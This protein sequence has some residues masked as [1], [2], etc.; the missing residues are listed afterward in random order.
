WDAISSTVLAFT[1]ANSNTTTG[2]KYSSYHVAY[3]RAIA[4]DEDSGTVYVGGYFSYYGLA[5]TDAGR[6]TFNGLMKASADSASRTTWSQVTTGSSVGLY[7]STVNTSS[8]VH[9]LTWV[10]NDGV[11]V[12]G[13]FTKLGGATPASQSS[14]A[15]T[16]IRYLAR[17]PSTGGSAGQ[18]VAAGGGSAGTAWL[19]STVKGMIGPVSVTKSGSSANYFIPFG[20]FTNA[21][22]VAVNDA[23]GLMATDASS[24]SA[25]AAAAPLNN[26]V[27]AVAVTADNRYVYVG[28][29]FTSLGGVANANYLA[30]YD[31]TT[32]AWSV[33]T[34]WYSSATTSRF[35][36]RA[37]KISGSYI[38][39]AGISETSKGQYVYR[40]SANAPA[41]VSPT[42]PTAVSGTYITAS[43]G[44][45]T[46]VINAIEFD[47]SGRLV[48]GGSFTKLN[49]TACPTASIGTIKNLFRVVLAGT[50]ACEVIGGVSPVSDSGKVNT[51]VSGFVDGASL[52]FVGGE[53]Q[54]IDSDATLDNVAVWDDSG[55]SAGTGDWLGLGSVSGDGPVQNPVYALALNGSS[56]YVGGSFSDAG[57]VS[58][59]DALAA[60]NLSSNSWSSLGTTPGGTVR[61][62]AQI[63]STLYVGGSFDGTDTLPT[64]RG[65]I[66]IALA[67]AGASPSTSVATK[68]GRTGGSITGGA[69]YTMAK[70]RI[71]SGDTADNFIY[72]G[73]TFTD[74]GQ[75]ATGDRIGLVHPTV[76]DISLSG[77]IADVGMDASP[78]TLVA[79]ADSGLTVTA[80]N[81]TPSR[82]TWTANQITLLSIGTC[83][84]LFD[85][86][87]GGGFAAA[88][89]Q[90]VTFEILKGSDSISF[91]Q[92]AD[93]SYSPSAFDPSISAAS[94]RNPSVQVAAG[95]S[96][97]CRMV[98]G[99]VEMLAA[100]AC[101]LT[102][103]LGDS[104]DWNAAEDVTRSFTVSQASQTISFTQPGEQEVGTNLVLAATSSS[105]LSV[106][107]SSAS[108]GICSVS[109]STVT[110]LTGGDCEIV[111]AQ[112]GNTQYQAASNV[113]RTFKVWPT[114]R[115]DLAWNTWE[116]PSNSLTVGAEV[117]VRALAQQLGNAGVTTEVEWAS[118]TPSVCTVSSTLGNGRRTVTPVSPG[119]CV[120]SLS[121]S[122]DSSYRALSAR[123]ASMTVEA[124]PT[125][126]TP[127]PTTTTE[128]PS[129]T[130]VATVAP[131]TTAATSSQSA[132]TINN[133][134]VLPKSGKAGFK[135]VTVPLKPTVRGEVISKISS[136]PRTVCNAGNFGTSK[137]PVWKVVM[138]KPGRC[139]IKMTLKTPAGKYY[140]SSTTIIVR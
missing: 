49:E 81:S 89:Q 43:S 40:A 124:A 102:A 67:S 6:T 136:S 41:A 69:I 97:V 55:G 61:A 86:A 78:I 38:Y 137:K 62:L 129:T 133:T 68:V 140:N 120:L 34:W 18:I 119:S 4:V 7:N 95:S 90:T 22:N 30:V 33:P 123:I 126:T 21:G 57:G 3:P 116:F 63:G 36:V 20:F 88:T 135:P 8:Y 48:V 56:L 100:G 113:S 53:F 105:S 5:S 111:A 87:G 112:S 59:A 104:T 32:E 82:C 84:I 23:A 65:L 83:T 74:L 60:V 107:Y 11:Y 96:S 77:S 47:A 92:L 108:T 72:I 50:E 128:P 79:E 31:R 9:G 75:D 29:D 130:V 118:S 35:K 10:D 117:T 98:S 52:L 94:S 19:N 134:Y 80:T 64:T 71:G 13:Q 93:R 37:L 16:D 70:K 121:R 66:Q 26:D 131:T 54:N 15:E 42:T 39:V 46:H 110:F 125:T 73:G 99:A 132:L 76:N 51:I 58:A 14:T 106:S 115:Y 103:S 127:P 122:S 139:A 114:S 85:Q 2:L 44:G 91:P 17:I 101:E 12:G 109:S 45:T 25:F 27:Y 138:S 1:N 24:W 28:G